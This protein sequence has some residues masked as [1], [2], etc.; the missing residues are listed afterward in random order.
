M[1]KWVRGFDDWKQDVTIHSPNCEGDDTHGT[2][3]EN[4]KVE[5]ENSDSTNN[6]GYEDDDNDRTEK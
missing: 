1:P 2:A 4:I 3:E 5:N 6:E